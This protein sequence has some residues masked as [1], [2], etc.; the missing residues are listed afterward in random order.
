MVTRR[1]QHGPNRLLHQHRIRSTRDSP[2]APAIA[3]RGAL[4]RE[5]G[6]VRGGRSK[7]GKT[8]VTQDDAADEP[9]GE[10]PTDTQRDR[11]HNLIDQLARLDTVDFYIRL[12]GAAKELG[13][14]EKRV[15]DSVKYERRKIG[16]QQKAARDEAD[17]VTRLKIGS[18]VEIADRVREDMFANEQLYI[19]AEGSFYHWNGRLW[20]ELDDP[21]VQEKFIERYDG[22]RYGDKGMIRLNQTHVKSITKF[23]AHKVGFKDFFDNKPAGVNLSNG[24]I[25][26]KD[27]GTYELVPHDPGQLTRHILPGSY[28]PGFAGVPADSLL[29]RYL[30]GIFRNDPEAVEKTLLLQEAAGTALIGASKAWLRQLKALILLGRS[31]NNGK[32]EFLALI[33]GLA[34]GA[35]SHVAAHQFDEKNIVIALR[36]ANL[37]TAGELTSSQAIA[38]DVFK[39]AVTLEYIHGKILFEDIVVFRPQA[40]LVFACNKLPPFLGGID[41][42]CRRRLLPVEFARTIPED[43]QIRDIAAKILDQ[44]YDVLLNWAIEGAARLIWQQGFTVPQSSIDI[45]DQ[46]VR[47]TDSV[48]AWIKERVRETDEKPGW[49][50]YKPSQALDMFYQWAE[51]N[52]HD[53]RFLPKMQ[54]FAARMADAFPGCKRTAKSNRLRGIVILTSDAA[55][56]Q[57]DMRQESPAHDAGLWTLMDKADAEHRNGLSPAFMANML[58]DY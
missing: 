41:K 56:I 9:C 48:V 27:D 1:G 8:G 53:K 37:N 55:D 15:E 30:S 51:Q 42:G 10:E 17:D 20:E 36:G 2:I 23:L 12:P 28:K 19:H 46:W 35:C 5:C 58:G 34:G 6:A 32:S 14:T 29:G 49:Q 38:S 18:D 3:G 31:A 24:F 57:D 52:H 16:Q 4:Y 39:K 7:E 50:G 21:D 47:D 22:A 44:E 26:F 54:E 45:L 25:A 43:E 13:W 11:T 40:Q 33:E